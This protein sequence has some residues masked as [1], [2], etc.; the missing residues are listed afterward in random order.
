[1]GVFVSQIYYRALCLLCFVLATASFL[2][3]LNGHRIIGGFA[4][5]DKVAHF[6]IFLVL[7]ALLWKGFKLTILAAF[8][9][10]GTYGGAI[11]LVQ[12]YF[13]RRNGDWWDFL[14]DVGGVSCFYLLRKLWHTLRPRSQR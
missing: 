12:H 5:L 8:L 13:T 2:A 9:L 11:E 1:M 4:H 7:A 3:E 14:A 10:L 6:G